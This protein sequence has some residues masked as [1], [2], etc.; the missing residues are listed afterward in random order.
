[1]CSADKG[2]QIR[3]GV[4][5]CWPCK[6]QFPEG[7]KQR[8]RVNDFYRERGNLMRCSLSP[9]FRRDS[10]KLYL[11]AGEKVQTTEERKK[12]LQVLLSCSQAGPGRKAKQDQEEISCNLVHTF[13][14]GSVHLHSH[15]SHA[16]R[17]EI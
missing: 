12:G 3:G 4:S 8:R 2:D 5:S 14:P 16:Y 11:E 6:C 17:D 9:H 15:D 13:F 10:V 1:M 7:P